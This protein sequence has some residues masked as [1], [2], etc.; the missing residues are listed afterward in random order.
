M[1]LQ[2]SEGH[3]QYVKHEALFIACRIK[4]HTVS[5]NQLM[6]VKSVFLFIYFFHF[7][8]A[9]LSESAAAQLVQV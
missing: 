5:G 1:C 3:L 8:F 2:T 9:V 4:H 7:S 6:R